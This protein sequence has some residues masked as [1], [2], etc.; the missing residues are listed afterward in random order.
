MKIRRVIEQREEAQLGNTLFK[1]GRENENTCLFYMFAYR[2]SN[3]Q[4]GQKYVYSI[5]RSLFFS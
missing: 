5:T 3:I 4:C 1:R 2:K